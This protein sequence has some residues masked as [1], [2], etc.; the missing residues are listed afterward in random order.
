MASKKKARK[1]AFRSQG[2]DFEAR[3]RAD[4]NED[5]VSLSWL[6]DPPDDEDIPE[7]VVEAKSEGKRARQSLASTKKTHR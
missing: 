1:V 3:F 2:R 4:D 6:G 7:L 5:S